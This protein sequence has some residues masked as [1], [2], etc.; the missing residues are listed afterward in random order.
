MYHPRRDGSSQSAALPA[1]KRAAVDTALVGRILLVRSDADAVERTVIFVAV[2]ML[3]VFDA[4][5]N[6]A[7]Y[8]IFMKHFIHLISD[9][10]LPDILIIAESSSAMHTIVIW[11]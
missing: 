4:A 3:A 7:V 1:L 5:A 9:Y 2:V 11:Q 8:M 6:T 10:Q